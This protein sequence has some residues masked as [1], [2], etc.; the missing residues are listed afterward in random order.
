MNDYFAS[1]LARE[2]QADFVR[3]VEHDELAARVHLADRLRRASGVAR[4]AEGGVGRFVIMAVAAIALVLALAAP[5]AAS[6]PGCSAF[7][8]ASAAGGQKAIPG[9]EGIPF[10]Q[11][12]HVYFQTGPGAI[13]TIVAGEHFA[14]CN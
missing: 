10:G 2:R 7:G 5:A 1:Q 4:I 11:V 3:E 14:M 9:L 13:S 12:I 6:A 8:A